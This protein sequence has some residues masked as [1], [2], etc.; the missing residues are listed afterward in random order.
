MLSFCRSRCADLNHRPYG[1]KPLGF[2]GRAEEI[3]KARRPVNLKP[4]HHVAEPFTYFYA[5]ALPSEWTPS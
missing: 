5:F 2:I 4:V 1:V 3:F